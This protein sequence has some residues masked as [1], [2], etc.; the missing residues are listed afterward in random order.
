MAD[1]DRSA[2]TRK[3]AATTTAKE[4]D[5]GR[6]CT[7]VVISTDG[8]CYV[9]FDQPADT[10]SLRLPADEVIHFPVNFTKISVLA[11]T[12]ANVYVVGLR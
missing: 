12:T 1:I 6:L 11:A 7:G 4:E 5:F 2:D 10:G 9:D 3:I 8:I